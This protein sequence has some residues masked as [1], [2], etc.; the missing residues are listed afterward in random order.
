MDGR[1]VSPGSFGSTLVGS[2]RVKSSSRVYWGPEYSF[3]LLTTKFDVAKP[4]TNTTPSATDHGGRGSVLLQGVEVGRR[5]L[6]DLWLSRYTDLGKT[7]PNINSMNHSRRQTKREK[8]TKVSLYSLRRNLQG[9]LKSLRRRGPK[10]TSRV[11]QTTS[12]IRG[13]RK[14]YDAKGDYR[15]SRKLTYS[16]PLH[17]R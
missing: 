1:L 12:H 8:Y 10:E 3:L 15:R 4:R 14:V 16:L 7:I 11:E 13:R 9:R 5:V 17:Q 6:I 2:Y